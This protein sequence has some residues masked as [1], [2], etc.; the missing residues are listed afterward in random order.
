MTRLGIYLHLFTDWFSESEKQE[1]ADKL[2][3]CDPNRTNGKP[4]FPQY[5]STDELN[6]A[7]FINQKSWLLFS[8]FERPCSSS[9]AT[10]VELWANDEACK[11]MK[12][13]VQSLNV[14]NDAAERCIKLT[15]DFS[16]KFSKNEEEKQYIHSV[17]GSVEHH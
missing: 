17:R 16:A 4:E 5:S 7:T 10:S 12:L 2:L 14:V 3:Q 13:V 8:F 9:L 6:L 15:Q 11:T 1:A